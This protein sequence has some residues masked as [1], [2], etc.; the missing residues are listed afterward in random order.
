[1]NYSFGTSHPK[2]YD[3]TTEELLELKP[4]HIYAFMAN[5]VYGKPNPSDDDKPLNGRSSTLEYM[6]KAI[7]FFMPN[8]LAGWNVETRSGNPTRSVE[9]NELIKTVK[10]K[11]VRKEGK[12][13]SA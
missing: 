1:M 9:I 12:A 4:E 13:G 7:S 2:D 5:Q 11:E 3:F 6:K 10:K 8:K